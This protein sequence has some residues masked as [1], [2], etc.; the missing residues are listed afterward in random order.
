MEVSLSQ[1]APGLNNNEILT[2]IDL[3]LN[4]NEAQNSEIINVNLTPRLQS[5]DNMPPLSELPSYTEALKIKSSEANTNELP[6]GY[7]TNA[8][9]GSN[10]TRFPIVDNFDVI[11]ILKINKL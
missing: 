9:M 8:N 2:E 6:P 3:N 11:S 7:F 1:A 10:E 4:R 5:N